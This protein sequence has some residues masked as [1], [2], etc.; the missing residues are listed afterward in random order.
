MTRAS[1][2]ERP[3]ER[4]GSTWAPPTLQRLK[5]ARAAPAMA[6]GASFVVVGAAVAII[7]ASP[8]NL[9]A[10]ASLAAIPLVVWGTVRVPELVVAFILFSQILEAFELQTPIG[11]LSPGIVALLVFLAQKL[12]QVMATVSSPAYRLGIASLVAYVTGQAFQFLHGD[13]GLAA[14]QMIT[15]SSFAAFVVLGMYIGTRRSHLGAAAI[16]AATGLVTLAGLA[17]AGDLSI[18]PL[19]PAASSSAREILGVVTSF[20]RNLGLQTVALGLLLSSCVPWLALR[21]RSPTRFWIR[22]VCITVLAFIWLAALFVFQ[23]RSMVLEVPAGILLVW[24]LA[25]RRFST[26][27]MLTGLSAAAVVV[28]GLY[29]SA[30]TEATSA[31]STQL[32]TESYVAA[33]REFIGNP[34]VLLVGT[35]PRE[36]HL[37]VNA[38]LTYGS[39][40]PASAPI[41]NLLIETILLGGVISGIGLLLLLLAP[42]FRVVRCA[43]R[44]GRF[45]GQIAVAVSAVGIVFLE[46]SVWPGIANSAPLWITLGCAAAVA[47]NGP[48]GDEQGVLPQ[49]RS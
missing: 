26:G 33:L 46:A 6:I 24:S 27:V 31:V 48:P 3:Y 45:D 35:D 47:A 44:A 18:I 16:G 43:R 41:H 11:T 32:R 49:A 23:I 10:L 42:V 13:A 29:L 15:A 19:P 9:V 30:S 28:L 25:N 21:I 22:A 12:P 39:L 37:M 14:R 17:L 36:F 8:V 38:T 5:I 20:G 7:G 40:I 2:S 34:S 1:H 4:T